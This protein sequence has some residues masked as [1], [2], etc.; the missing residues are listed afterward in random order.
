MW[1]SSGMPD[2]PTSK[3]I[4][5]DCYG[6]LVDWHGGY[7]AILEPLFSER[8]PKILQ[9]YHA[10]EHLVEE[11]TPHL[12]YRDVL[13]ESLREAAARAGIHLSDGEASSLTDQWEKLHPFP[14]VEVALEELRSL[15]FQLG[16]LTN[17]DND[18]F[19]KT[20]AQFTQRFDAVITAEMVLDYKPSTTHFR[21]FQRST[22]ATSANWIHAACSWFHDLPPARAMGIRSIWVDREETGQ[23]PSMATRRITSAAELVNTVRSLES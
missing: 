17:C 16:V 20:H 12:S 14:D 13:T 18:L 7:R 10:V 2:A 9:N 4:T 6:T 23:D 22:G 5:F 1:Q 19:E 8:T 15:G 21:R 11:R 3:W